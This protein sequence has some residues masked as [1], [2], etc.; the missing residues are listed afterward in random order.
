MT[1]SKIDESTNCQITQG[2]QIDAYIMKMTLAFID[3][4][5]KVNF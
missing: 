3:F 5:S 4:Q 1:R 2:G